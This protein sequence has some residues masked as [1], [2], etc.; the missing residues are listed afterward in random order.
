MGAG[1]PRPQTP[2]RGNA[3]VSGGS[4][5]AP[6]GAFSGR[7]VRPQLRQFRLRWALQQLLVGPPVFLNLSAGLL[8]PMV[9]GWASCLS[10]VLS[11]FTA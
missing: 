2:P 6:H 10:E 7:G 9:L 3:Q 11:D 4:L 8:E 1:N 5:E